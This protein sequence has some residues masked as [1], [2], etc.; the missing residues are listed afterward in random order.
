MI[1][2]GLA[3]MK[4][5]TLEEVIMKKRFIRGAVAVSLL[6]IVTSVIACRH[7]SGR[8]F[9]KFAL[10]AMNKR[11]ASELDLNESQH[12]SLEAITAEFKA[13][14]T[15]IHAGSKERRIQAADLIRQDVIDRVAVDQ[16]I[17]ERRDK[18][19]EL[20]DLAVDRLIAFHAVL[21]PEQREKIADHIKSRVDKKCRF[22]D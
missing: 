20:A 18:I 16:M 4:N 15:E 10:E 21:T 2:Q 1:M 22:R 6:V 14:M 7:H 13:K 17:A 19:L 3:L 9:D 5:L 8:G 11:I 12:A